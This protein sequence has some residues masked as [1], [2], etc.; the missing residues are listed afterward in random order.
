MSK[1]SSDQGG[2]VYA[3]RRAHTAALMRAAA[4][5]A[6]PGL[7]VGG[8][9]PADLS[10]PI[11]IL[12][13]G[14]ASRAMTVAAVAR[15][16][17]DFVDGLATAPA[18]LSDAAGWPER[19][20]VLAC[21]HPWPTARNRAAA[22]EVRGYVRGLPADRTLLVLVSG[23]ASAHLALPRS[24]VSLEDLITITRELQR[25]GA[26]IEELNMVRRHCEQLKGGGLAQVCGAGRIEALIL[27]DVIGDRPHVIASGPVSVDPTTFRDALGVLTR[28]GLEDSAPSVTRCLRDGEAGRQPETLKSLQGV[29]CRVHARII[30]A[31]RLVVEACAAEARVLGFE[32]AWEGHEVTGEASKV[33]ADLIGRAGRGL[34]AHAQAFIVGGEPTVDARG[35]SGVGGPSQELA[36]AVLASSHGL[37]RWSLLA[38]STDGKDGPTDA[39]G[40]IVDADTVKAAQ[41]AGVNLDLALRQHDSH[42]ALG[43]L[44]ALVRTGD[45]GTNLNHVAV[46]LRY[47]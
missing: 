24:G 33:G 47:P 3:D 36:L 8:S 26:T 14:R 37:A 4:R 15:L 31:N 13:I 12:A 2:P 25:A 39:A 21:D 40:A 29:R 32:V 35:A 27:S 46:A 23:G 9:W 17:S 10:G 41:A 19:V 28:F 1:S 7:A 5:A 38:L 45:T 34:V 22:E 44:G 30:A 11:S 20:R 18:A 6:D 16:G 42:G 43:R